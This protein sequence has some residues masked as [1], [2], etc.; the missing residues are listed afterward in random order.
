[1]SSKSSYFSEIQT[2]TLSWIWLM[3]SA[4]LVVVLAV[5]WTLEIQGVFQNTD[6]KIVDI[7][8]AAIV[9]VPVF[10]VLYFLFRTMKLEVTINSEGL[11]WK[12]PPF[13]RQAKLIKKSEIISFKVGEYKPIKEYGGWGFRQTKKGSKKVA[14]NVSGNIGLELILKNSHTV[15]FG[16]KRR[17][18]M[19]FAMRKMM[20]VSSHV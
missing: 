13:V 4:L 7:Q 1:M 3:I 14:Y 12:Y 2:F 19:E 20:E 16:T 11:K 17:E 8:W 10:V 9:Q 15:L 5:V 18:A 6:F